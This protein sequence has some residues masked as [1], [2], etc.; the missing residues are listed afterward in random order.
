M[1]CSF[2]DVTKLLVKK[3]DRP[4]YQTKWTEIAVYEKE[5]LVGTVCFFAERGGEN[6][7]PPVLEEQ[8]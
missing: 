4:D 5:K 6:I 2:Y 3:Y 7:R 1:E 8:A